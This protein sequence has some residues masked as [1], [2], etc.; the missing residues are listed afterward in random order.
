[1]PSLTP[2]QAHFMNAAAH[3]PAFALKAGI[4]QS[5]AREFH[6]ADKQKAAKT[7]TRP[8]WQKWKSF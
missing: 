3:N 8:L 1:M 6:N 5:V 4:P 2:K 7:G